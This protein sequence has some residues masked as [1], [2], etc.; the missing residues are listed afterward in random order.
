MQRFLAII[1]SFFI[2][3]FMVGCNSKNVVSDTI[4]SDSSKFSEELNST[5]DIGNTATENQI[6]SSDSNQNE[7]PTSR[8]E[9]STSSSDISVSNNESSMNSSISVSS[10]S[11]QS[12]NNT[13]SS[14][15]SSSGNSNTESSNT[16]FRAT[17]N[18][19]TCKKLEGN[20]VVLFLFADDSESNWDS[21]TLSKFEASQ[22]Q[23]ALTYLEEKAAQYGKNLKFIKKS[24]SVIGGQN[25]IYSKAIKKDGSSYDISYDALEN[26][27]ENMGYGTSD[28]LFTE[29]RKEYPNYEIVPIILLNKDGTSYARHAATADSAM[30]DHCIVFIRNLGITSAPFLPGNRTSTIAHE[31]LHLYGA[32]DFYNMEGRS[33]LAGEYYPSDIMYYVDGFINRNKISDFTAYSVGWTDDI[34]DICYNENWWK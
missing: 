32:E 15:V 5:S 8:Q 31:I 12:S 22:T 17:Y 9:T 25:T 13:I 28:G 6:T 27:C 2:A 24:Y 16:S 23:K 11:G 10:T 21:D 19:G 33:A 20:I 1:L 7:N 30:P 14:N 4:S 3:V 26:I 29:V 34:P 18:L